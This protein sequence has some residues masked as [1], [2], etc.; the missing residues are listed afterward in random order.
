VQDSIVQDS[1]VQDF[2]VRDYIVQDPDKLIAELADKA[3][4]MPAGDR[5]MLGIIGYP[6]AGKS[7]TAQL[8]VDGVNKAQNGGKAVAVVV[9]MDGFHRYNQELKEL[10]LFELKG[11]PDSFDGRAF[12]DLLGKIKANKGKTIGCPCFDRAIEEPTPDAILV[13]PEHKIV[14]VEGNYLLLD[15]PPWDKV[16]PTLDEVWFIDCDMTEVESRLRARHH[17]GGR[18][19]EAARI[20]MESTDLPNAR[21]IEKTRERADRVIRLNLQPQLET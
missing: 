18:N 7:T 14:V 5:F 8:L 6:G 4:A 3:S 12:V 21:L 19:P 17:K 10:Q 13:K 2:I 1:I 9:P 16:R 11:V 20:K 15:T